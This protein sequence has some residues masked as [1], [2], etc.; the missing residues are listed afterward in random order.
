MR[1]G[2]YERI[3]IEVAAEV[4]LSNTDKVISILGN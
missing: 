1:G 2:S 4:L 3:D